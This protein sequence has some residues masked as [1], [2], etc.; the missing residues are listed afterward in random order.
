[1]CMICSGIKNNKL[2]LDQARE[3]Y[4]EFI[5]LDLIDEE[6]QE[7]IEMLLAEAESDE[8]YW[9]SAKKDYLRSRNDYEDDGEEELPVDEIFENIDEE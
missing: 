9:N 2:T 1:M 8:F 4:E 5:E 7:E 6:H 3:K